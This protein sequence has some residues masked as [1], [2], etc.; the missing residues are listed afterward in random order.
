VT[1]VDAEQLW[2][3]FSVEPVFSVTG[4]QDWAP[5]W[6]LEKSLRMAADL[7]IPFHVFATNRSPLLDGRPGL[8]VGIHPN[9]L[10]GSTHGDTGDEVVDHCLELFP[11]ART[12]RSH[13]FAESTPD[14][15]S[16]RRRGI[17][18]DSNDCLHLQ[19]GITPQMHCSGLLRIPVFLEDDVL[20]AHVASVPRF[21]ELLPTLFSP[22]LKVFN[23]HPALLA[24]NTPSAAAYEDAR[25]DLYGGGSF[26]VPPQESARGIADLLRE[27]VGEVR[28]RGFDFE[29]FEAIVDEALS[30]VSRTFPDGLCGWR[31]PDQGHR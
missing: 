2:G 24:L 20:L 1:G 30:A 7:G 25:G 3:R 16:L 18:A 26:P 29:S 21:E 6:A 14:M 10:R 12:S 9:F 19:P 15:I 8:G 28:E 13:C 5:D 22:G 23:F 27:L 17:V 11:A 4:D 31:A